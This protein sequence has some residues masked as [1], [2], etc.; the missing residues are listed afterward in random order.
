MFQR[1]L[2]RLKLLNSFLAIVRDTSKTERVFEFVEGLGHDPELRTKFPHTASEAAFLAAPFEQGFPELDALRAMPA[3]SLGRALAAHMDALGVDFS[4]FD[5]A[6]TPSSE[7]EWFDRHGYETHDIW[8][9]LT[10]WGTGPANE[11]GLQGF[12][13]A[14]L[15]GLPAAG[16][17]TLAMIRG[18]L[19]GREELVPIVEAVVAGWQQ[20]R[21]AKPVFGV[22]WRPHFGRPLAEVQAEFGLEPVDSHSF[23]EVAELLA[24]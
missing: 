23:T 18:I 17:V 9:V 15:E 10:G 12:Y 19:G 14:Q 21:A 13:L 24:A 20:G 11:I 8:H 5:R 1:Y 6:A 16:L 7:F 22:D 2:S 3:G 4:A